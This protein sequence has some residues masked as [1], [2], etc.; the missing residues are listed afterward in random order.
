M[1]VVNGFM[2]GIFGLLLRERLE[3]EKL[4]GRDM[5]MILRRLKCSY[6]VDNASI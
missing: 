3:M 1:D 5:N 6:D 2:M 4:N